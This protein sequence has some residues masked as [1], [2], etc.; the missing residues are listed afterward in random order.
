MFGPLAGTARPTGGDCTAFLQGGPRP[1]QCHDLQSHPGKA[2]KVTR[3]F[4]SSVSRGARYTALVSHLWRGLRPSARECLAQRDYAAG[5]AVTALHASHFAALDRSQPDI[6]SVFIPGVEIIPRPVFPQ[7]FRGSFTELGRQD[8][9]VCGRLGLWPKQWSA[10]RI[11]AGTVKGFHIHPPHVP[12]GR[13]AGDW[14]R[15]LYGSPDADPRRRPYA[16]EQWDLMQP[17]AGSCEMLLLDERDGLERRTM[18]FFVDAGGAGLDSAGVVIPPGVAHAIRVESSADLLMVY[19][20]TVTFS[21]ELEG[22][23]AASVEFA[24]LPPEWTRFL[25]P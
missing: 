13:E 23:L 15:E 2:G 9:G 25:A 16:L 1:S 19:G 20:T 17:V 7:R 3:R 12:E 22:R 6:A 8:E 21:P 4:R 24:D 11:Y 18:R 5:G 14:F 10:T